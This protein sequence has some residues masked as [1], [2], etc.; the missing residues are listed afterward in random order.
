MPGGGAGN[1]YAAKRRVKNENPIAIE[2]E[3]RNVQFA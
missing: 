1:G 3:T 2:P